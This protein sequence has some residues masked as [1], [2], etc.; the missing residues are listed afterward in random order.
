MN[1]LYI[2]YSCNPYAGS[3]DKI[4]WCVPF[5][6]AKT[7]KVY[8]ITKE[9]QREF[10][11]KY[12]KLHTLKNIKFYYVDIPSI[13]KKIFKG[14]M[15]SGRLNIW[16][17][18]AFSVAKNICKENKIDIIHQI[19]PIE[20]RAIGDFGKIQNVKF[21]CGPLGGGEFIPK[22][23]QAY[24]KRHKIVEVIRI[25]INYCCRFKLK[26]T[27][28][29][30]RCAYI[31]FA[32][33]ETQ[34]FLSDRIML[35]CPYELCTE[36]GLRIDELINEKSICNKT[37]KDEKWSKKIVFL[38]AGRMIYRKGLEFLLDAL[39][40]I[41]QNLEYE[42]RVVGDGPELA[43]LCKKCKE[44]LNL[45]RHVHFAGAIPYAE[46]EKEYFKANVFIMPSIRETT[47]TVL[48]EAM[49]KGLPVISINKFGGATLLDVDTG[50]LYGGNSKEEYVENLREAI[51]ECIMNPD[52]VIRR[53]MN[54]RKKAA[55]Y[56][57]QEKH[58]KY[59]VIYRKLMELC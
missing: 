41:P 9:E 39:I 14:F 29:L 32:N 23:L 6:S 22:G 44:N 3:E 57:W 18:R 24:G 47:G 54:A 33:K 43:R 34:E 21:V 12:L 8:V 46:M 30:N 38:V 53:G 11:E 15:Y 37:I 16:N 40:K 35:K 59:Q 4:G 31:M 26:I 20:F 25:A 28:N 49:S 58:K 19:T 27:G 52:E 17:K 56:T 7:N 13:Y 42:V 48:L 45:S 55:D 2:A 50:F 5:E 36:I 51:M 10:I 1:I